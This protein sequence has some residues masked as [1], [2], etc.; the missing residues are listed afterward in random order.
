MTANAAT[1][2][3]PGLAV[4]AESAPA[5]PK[6]ARRSTRKPAAQP[7][8]PA[9]TATVEDTVMQSVADAMQEAAA[10]AS[11]H[12]AKVRSAVGKIAPAT[13]QGASRL[14]YTGPYFLAYGVVYATV[15]LAQSLPQENP[16]MKGFHDGAQAA[17]DALKANR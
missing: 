9:K 8:A 11:E 3:G 10:T 7:E 6:T 13:I 17:T 5:K 1:A 15:F 2:D 16:V 4:G 12:A 14:A